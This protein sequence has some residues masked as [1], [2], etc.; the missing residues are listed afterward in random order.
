MKYSCE[1]IQDLLPLYHDEA[2]SEASRKIVEEHLAECIGCSVMAKRMKDYTYENTLHEERN[3]VVE[4]HTKKVL[5]KS[6]IVGISVAS[7]LMIPILVTFTVNLAT[8]RTLDWFFIVLFS[9]LTVAS[10]T[11]VPLVM[12]E[13]KFLWSIGTFTASLL[14]LLL[15]IN[16]FTGGGW[17]F[18]AAVPVVFGLSVV[19]L[20]I[21]IY[22]VPLKGFFANHKGLLV[23]LIN[24][25]LL[26]TLIITIGLYTGSAGYWRPA[27]MITTGMI[28]FP[29]L[30][31][32]IIRYLK[33]IRQVKVNGFIKAGLCIL[34]AGTISTVANS[35]ISFVLGREWI[36]GIGHAN[37]SDWS[38]YTL[39]NAN[40]D[41]IILLSAIVL[42]GIFLLVGWIRRK[43]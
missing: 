16:A 24:T 28:I 42:G 41:L 6:V 4:R 11:V 9:L 15:T 7:V 3:Q 10:I 38:D 43:K 30:F 25:A 18:V 19:F 20:P 26:Y 5:R 13:K 39:I 1:M 40:I 12:P 27:L 33:A 17:F 37:L 36:F 31:F 35:Y 2:C 29:W 8:G 21:A 14:L 22:Q 23:M 34:V 32:G